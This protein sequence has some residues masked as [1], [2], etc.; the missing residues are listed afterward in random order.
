MVT[1]KNQTKVEGIMSNRRDFL[2]ATVAVSA[3]SALSACSLTQQPGKKSDLSENNP[4]PHFP[5]GIIYTK[6]NPGKWAKKVGGHLPEVKVDGNK[7]TIITNHG[8]SR[9]H[10]IVKH[11]IVTIDGQVLAE[12]TFSPLDEEPISVFELSVKDTELYATSFCN[13]HDLWLTTFKV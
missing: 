6:E 2:K 7:V 8:M 4:E 12:Q 5:L 10:F 3:T 1:I 11:S 9:R 13:K